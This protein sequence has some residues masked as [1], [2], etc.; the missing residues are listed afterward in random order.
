MHGS[1]DGI[2]IYIYARDHNPPHFHAYY[3]EFEVIIRIG[4]LEVLAGELPS[5]Q[6]KRV[7][8]WAKPIQN[9]LLEEFLRLQAI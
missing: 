1:F 7:K 4:S 2:R 6:L 8:K 9:Y 5:K 3:G